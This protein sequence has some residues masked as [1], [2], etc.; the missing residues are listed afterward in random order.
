MLIAIALYEFRYKR[1]IELRVSSGVVSHIHG[2]LIASA[3]VYL[4]LVVFS[5]LSS[6]LALESI[7]PVQDAELVVHYVEHCITLSC[8][9]LTS[10]FSL[11]AAR[12]LPRGTREFLIKSLVSSMLASYAFY[13]SITVLEVVFNGRGWRLYTFT[14]L[15]LLSESIVLGFVIVLL[16]TVYLAGISVFKRF[17]SIETM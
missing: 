8:L 17:V 11:L 6:T 1:R 4:S 13:L 10:L 16:T 9:M 15:H 3:V 2:L 12:S 5:P 7:T 14:Y